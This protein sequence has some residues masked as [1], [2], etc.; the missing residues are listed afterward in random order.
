[1]P[2][3]DPLDGG[4][5]ARVLFLLEKP[6]PMTSA[7]GAA[8][9]RIGSG[10]I[11]RDNDDPTAEAIREF[12][13]C[14]GLS[15]QETVIWNVV[16]WWNG[17]RAINRSELLQGTEQVIRLIE[18]LPRLRAAVLV[19]KR[20]QRAKLHLVGRGVEILTSDHPSPLVKARWPDRWA[21]IASEWSKVR[22][23]L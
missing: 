2:D 22:Q 13:R 18:L 1:M 10:F 14:A 9:R 20:A 6:G 5:G 11:S 21:A 15:R 17:T 8:G 3:F 19:G 7:S 16:P 23:R 4:T 12:M